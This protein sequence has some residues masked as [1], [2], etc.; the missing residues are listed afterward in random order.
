MTPYETLLSESQE[1]MLIIVKKGH[2]Q[3]VV[4]IFEK[5]D[6]PYA[7]V[8]VV[9]DDGMMRVLDHGKLAVEIPAAKL[10]D[11]APLYSREWKA[12]PEP[13]PL[14]FSTLA[15]V[16]EKAALLALLAHPTIASKQWVWRQYDHMV[17]IGCAVLPGSDAAVFI[18]R[19][20]D[21]ILAATS[22]CNS[23][24]VLQDPREGARIAIAEAARNLTCS[25]ARLLAVTDN[26]NFANPHNPELFW[27][28][29]ESVEG[30]AEGC[31]EFGT[32]VTGG[33]VS[34][35]NQSPAGPIDPSPTVGMVGL[36]DDAKHITTQAFKSAGDVIILAGPVLD[37]AA[38]DLS[39]GA[40]HYMKVVHG[41]KAGRTP[42][43][44]FDLEK[45]VQ[46]AVLGL[47][48]EGLVK[49]AHDCSEG[50]LAVAIAESCIGGKLGATIELPS[51]PA[52]DK[53]PAHAARAALLF[54]ESQSR[55]I[56]GIAPENADRVLAAL[57]AAKIPHSRLGTVGGDKLSITAHGATLAATLA[58]VSDPFE[59]SI[60]RAM[61]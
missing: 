10:A 48:R 22:D 21:K 56:L 4:D 2:E 19:E 44:S 55:I 23:L 38:G 59:H 54:G 34:L 14:D 3:T 37:P 50:G 18:V 24:Y 33:N 5:W 17:R 11:D 46:A 7:E 52:L 49:S 15:A 41:Q 58:E 31:R 47:I 8:G 35:Y 30:L 61:A 60:E 9:K 36:I 32:P 42:R 43:L 29:R 45:R 40:S 28:L 51:G 6:L 13:A 39:L 16:D 25:G 12:R 53:Y 27:Q 20:A 57:A 26:L 1:R